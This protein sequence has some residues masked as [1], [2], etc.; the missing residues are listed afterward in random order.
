MG[1]RLCALVIFYS[2][3]YHEIII[4]IEMRG[5]CMG[6]CCRSFHRSYIACMLYSIFHMSCIH[7]YCSDV[8]MYECMPKTISACGRITQPHIAFNN[9]VILMCAQRCIRMLECIYVCVMSRRHTQST[10]EKRILHLIRQI[11]T[12]I[13]HNLIM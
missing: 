10:K 6:V 4:I 8:S 7:M 5:F 1:P 9:V 11:F 2:S 13:L 12:A 3:K